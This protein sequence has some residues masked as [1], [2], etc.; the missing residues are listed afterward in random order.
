MDGQEDSEKRRAPMLYY[1]ECLQD[2]GTRG[3]HISLAGCQARLKF[4]ALGR[5]S[6]Q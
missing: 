2:L 5:N 6:T 4:P 3:C 1:G